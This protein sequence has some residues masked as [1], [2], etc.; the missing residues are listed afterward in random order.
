MVLLFETDA[1][2]S[3]ARKLEVSGSPRPSSREMML[4]GH[5]TVVVGRVAGIEMDLVVLPQM[6]QIQHQD[7]LREGLMI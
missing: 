5:E 3:V 4:A 7:V 2:V 1:Q 6:L